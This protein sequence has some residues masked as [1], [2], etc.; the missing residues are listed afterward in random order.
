MAFRHG[1][2]W[3][4]L[5]TAISATVTADSAFTIAFG[6]APN[7]KGIEGA[8][9]ANKIVYAATYAEAVAQLGYS[10]DWE[11]WTLCEI[12]YNHFS[13]YGVGGIAFVNVFNMD[14][15]EMV[16]EKSLEDAPVIANRV[17]L[18]A[19]A[20]PLTVEVTKDDDT[21]LEIEKDF[22]LSWDK[23][24]SLVIT[25]I[26]DA[27]TETAVN[28]LWKDALPNVIESADVIGGIDVNT[29]EPTGMELISQ[30]F[31]K[32]RKVAAIIIAPGWS[33]DP[34]VAAVMNAKADLINGVFMQATAIVDIP[35]TMKYSEVA[36]WK[37]QNNYVL[38]HQIS[39]WPRLTL[40]GFKYYFSTHLS[41]LLA[42]VDRNRDNIPSQ[43]PSNQ[44]LRMDGA[45]LDDD[46][47]VNLGL[48]QANDMLNAN[49]IVTALN[50]ARGWTAW[51]NHMSCYPGETDPA[52]IWI[53]MHRM[54][55][56][57]GNSLPLTY[58][59]KVDLPLSPMIIDN[60]V[61]TENM[62]LNGIA[63]FHIAPGASLVYVPE[64]SNL[65]NGKAFF[66][67]RWCPYPPMQ[68]ILFGI[69]VDFMQMLAAV[70]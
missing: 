27:A 12:M 55:A 34:A 23:S 59:A 24:E 38:E 53:V 6:T 15:P 20:L 9:K 17:I 28:V 30:L 4:V 33:Q 39:C 49:G 3:D 29:G 58:W 41:A 26:G 45:C 1:V 69:E 46:T 54:N 43:S 36:E 57:K 61:D 70:A 51:G 11:S 14:D 21:P 66:H 32:F 18:T 42:V 47:P 67:L 37:N 5:P 22:V 8:G 10:N 60:I 35:A 40:G 25:L 48:D 56:W 65:I 44:N 63:P 62:Q 52:K 13:N 19:N 7:F 64:K 50:F 16:E 31:P 68:E 2:Y